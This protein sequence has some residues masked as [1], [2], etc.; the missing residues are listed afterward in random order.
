MK[1][2]ETFWNAA[3]E[4]YAKSSI[5]DEDAYQAS[6]DRT[7]SY[8][9]PTDMVLEVGAGTGSTALLLA[10]NVREII[11]TDISPNMVAIGKRKASEQ[12]VRN[13]DFAAADLFSDALP[14]G[15]FD[16]VMAFN[17]LHLIEDVAAASTR[18]NQLLKS[19]GLFISKSTCLNSGNLRIKFGLLKLAIPLMQFLGKAPYVNLMTI[20]ELEE[21]IIAGGF[22]I[23]E[24]GNYPVSPPNR[25]VVARKI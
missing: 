3:A 5:A 18:V 15:P 20:T 6:L 24:T 22:K 4:K 2:A 11:A 7:R 13:I 10:G 14:E 16:V 1:N 17:I 19:G 8:L 12:A 23:I 25:Y 21:A 9:K